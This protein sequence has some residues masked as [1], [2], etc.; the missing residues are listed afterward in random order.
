MVSLLVPWQRGCRQNERWEKG[1]ETRRP[2]S[3]LSL[4]SL[5]TGMWDLYGSLDISCIPK[6]IGSS[7]QTIANV[8]WSLSKVVE[9]KTCWPSLHW[10]ANRNVPLA[11][12]W[13][14]FNHFHKKTSKRATRC[15]WTRM[16]SPWRGQPMGGKGACLHHYIQ[17]SQR[18][19]Q[20]ACKRKQEPSYDLVRKLPLATSVWK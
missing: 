17:L 12:I 14:I 4:Y 6:G 16:G 20:S 10:K 8:F 3:D 5:K 15:R 11:S 9:T 1:R 18:A 13:W 7:R 19:L 2:R